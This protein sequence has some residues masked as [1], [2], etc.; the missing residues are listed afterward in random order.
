[1]TFG[2]ETCK[3][4]VVPVQT[5]IENKVLFIICQY[6]NIS[7]REQLLT[8]WV[9]SRVSPLI[10][11]SLANIKKSAD[12]FGPLKCSQFTDSYS[13]LSIIIKTQTSFKS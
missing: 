13:Q 1:M 3:L 7:S 9:K 2:M 10:F 4:L 5:Y 11:W 8:T 6:L 12:H